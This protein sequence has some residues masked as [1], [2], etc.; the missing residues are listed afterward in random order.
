M[1]IL[2]TDGPPQ[3]ESLPALC[4]ALRVFRIFLFLFSDP[5]KFS[6]QLCVDGFLAA[7]PVSFN[8]RA[9]TIAI[10]TPTS[11]GLNACWK[12]CTSSSEAPPE[13]FC[14]LHPNTGP[15]KALKVK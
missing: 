14:K 13:T 11:I 1:Q 5:F 9:N 10:T 3:W 2:H 6:I 7:G 8:K 15:S 4:I 12:C